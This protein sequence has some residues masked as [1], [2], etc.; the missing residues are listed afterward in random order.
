[1]THD[2][3]HHSVIR[4]AVFVLVADQLSKIV[5]ALNVGGVFMPV[6]NPDYSLGVIAAPM[7]VLIAV[8]AVTLVAA[9]RY[10]MALARA[11]RIS[12]WVPSAILGGAAS[13][14]AD[15]F[16][17]GA[18]RDFIPTP[19]V[20]FNVADVAIICGITAFL[21]SLARPVSRESMT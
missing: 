21:W 16:V 11:G 2:S 3:I 5:G 9:G 8:S 6:H 13:N 4:N 12:V 17:F 19:L 18:V 14:L 1:M 7:F 20:I 15:R 10:G